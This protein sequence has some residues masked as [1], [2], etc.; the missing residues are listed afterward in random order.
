MKCLILFAAICIAV[1][2]IPCSLLSTEI[3]ALP[4]I[5]KEK[6]GFIGI[7]ISKGAPEEQ[8]MTMWEIFLSENAGA[9]NTEIMATLF[10]IFKEAI[11]DMNEDKA[12]WLQKLK[13]HNDIAEALGDYLGDL[14]DDADSWTT[15]TSSAPKP[16]KTVS[17]TTKKGDT[18]EESSRAKHIVEMIAKMSKNAD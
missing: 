4:A 7:A 9:S 14:A 13:N 15:E 2:C 16:I 12:Y 18:K 6:A 5:Q 3:V 11:D 17:K 8:V 10:Y 1:T